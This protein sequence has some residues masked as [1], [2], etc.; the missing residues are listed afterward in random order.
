[1]KIKFILKAVLVIFFLFTI[2][3]AACNCGSDT[4]ST[5]PGDGSDDGDGDGFG[6]FDDGSSDINELPNGIAIN[7]EVDGVTIET[8]ENDVDTSASL[9]T[10]DANDYVLIIIVTNNE[11]DND[12]II[13]IAFGIDSGYLSSNFEENVTYELIASDLGIVSLGTI[14][15]TIAGDTES[16]NIDTALINFESLDLD[17]EDSTISGVMQV[18]SND[19]NSELTVSFD[20]MLMMIS[21]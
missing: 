12:E 8:D 11:S 16:Y 17:I 18:Y 13:Q 3:L 19:T 21:T 2:S 10:Y 9:L 5:D 4:T 14:E 6:F 20:G 15:Y 7:G 1:M